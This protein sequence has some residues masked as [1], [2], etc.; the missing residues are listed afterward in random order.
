MNILVVEDEAMTQLF[1]K[2]ILEEVGYNVAV[3]GSAEHAMMVETSDP[4]DT[5]IID[6]HLADGMNGYDFVKLIRGRWP[7]P[8]VVFISGNRANIAGKSL[9]ANECFLPKPFGAEE[10]IAAVRSVS[11]GT[12]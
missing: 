8:G 2:M 6:I 12:R 4:P 10:L 11:G 5:L 3:K 7:Q 1:V 9:A